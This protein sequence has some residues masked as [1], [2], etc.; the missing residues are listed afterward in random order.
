MRSSKAS[1]GTL[2]LAKVAKG[3]LLLAALACANA[4]RAHHSISMFDI[5]TPVWLQGKVVDYVRA[6]PHARITL[7][8]TGAD[9]RVQ[10]WFIDGP[11]LSRLGRMLA[12][13]ALGDVLE[14]CG[15]ALKPE[16]ATRFAESER[17][18]SAAGM[19]HGHLLVKA[20][21][22]MLSWGPYGKLD[23]CIRASDTPDKWVAFLDSDPMAQQLWCFRSNLVRISSVASPAFAEEVD[24]RIAT[25]CPK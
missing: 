8:A 22:R 9:G 1:S 7:E 23:N 11:S 5:A 15:F 19:V 4:A 12:E 6:N 17:A 13:P 16:H 18:S 10:R 21:G 14:V 3:A 2:P 25:P 20:D 24:R